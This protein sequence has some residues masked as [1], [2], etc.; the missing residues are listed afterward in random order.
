M[1][2]D[3]KRQAINNFITETYCDEERYQNKHKNLYNKAMSLN[4]DQCNL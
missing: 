3:Y 1:V 2:L 4:T